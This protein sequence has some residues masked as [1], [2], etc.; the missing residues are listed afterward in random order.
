M[1]TLTRTRPAPLNPGEVYTGTPEQI[2]ADVMA[3]Y[4]TRVEAFIASRMYRLDWQLAEDLAQDT[5]VHLWRWHLTRGTVLDERVFG[6]LA[7]IARQMLC[8]HLRLMSSHESAVDLTDP[9]NAATRAAT[10]PPMDTPHLAHLYTELD[11]AKDVLV[12]A[13][14]TYQ[15]AHRTTVNARNGLHHTVRPEVIARCHAKVEQL[16]DVEQQALLAFQSAAA[17]VA[18]CRAAWNAAAGAQSTMVA[19]R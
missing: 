7:Q 14:A 6:L 17:E 16:A 15:R 4:R 5:F 8:Q 18:R 11:Q 10:A 12:T 3:T 2:L 19:T 13:A 9:A 1:S